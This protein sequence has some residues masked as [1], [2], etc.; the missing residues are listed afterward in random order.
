MP[1]IRTSKLYVCYCRLWCAVLGCWLSGFSCRTAGYASR[2]RD[3]ARLQSCNIP[4]SG[5]T[6]CCPAPDPRQTAAEH[7]TLWAANTHTFSLE[8]LMMGIEV[9]ETCWAY[10]KYNKVHTVRYSWFFFSTHLCSVWI[11]LNTYLYT[12]RESKNL[13]KRCANLLISRSIT[14]L[15]SVRSLYK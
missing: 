11:F 8:F 6:P 5:R 9:P 1:I 10:H 14:L 7:G 2:K 13:P 3:V 4:L 15:F 12:E